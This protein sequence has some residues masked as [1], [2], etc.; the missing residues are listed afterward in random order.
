MLE[1]DVRSSIGF[2]TAIALV[3]ACGGTASPSA[4]PSM[5]SPATRGEPLAS[6][7]GAPAPPP[8]GSSAAS[9]D[10][11]SAALGWGRPDCSLVD[12]TPRSLVP[13]L[14]PGKKRN[15]KFPDRMGTPNA[16]VNS[17]CADQPDGPT[18]GAGFSTF[19]DDTVVSIKAATPAG[20]SGRGWPGNQCTFRLGLRHDSGVPVELGPDVVPPFNGITS[21]ARSRSAVWVELSFNGYTKEFPSGGNRVV[22]IDLCIGRV[23][24]TSDDG[25]SNGGLLLVG[26][27]LIAAFGFTGEP[28]Y[29][30]VLDAYSGKLVQKLPVLENI[31]PSKSWAP[32][33]KG[34]RCDAPGQLVGAATDPRIE[35]GLFLVDTNTGSSAF[36][37]EGLGP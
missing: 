1:R 6:V 28:R 17:S 20:R 21:L 16:R 33:W 15:P 9:A 34:G 10:P 7:S 37:L 32:N 11:G 24:W 25:I 18:G 14:K 23:I 27:Y 35:S 3:S 29:V 22:A 5:V 2:G 4:Q 12:W 26:D 19:V 8:S 36:E 31:C 30:H 13:L